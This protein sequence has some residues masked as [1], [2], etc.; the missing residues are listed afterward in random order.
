MSNSS[1]SARIKELGN[2]VGDGSMSLNRVIKSL[3]LQ[4]Y[5]QKHSQIY[6]HLYNS[7]K[8]DLL[9]QNKSSLATF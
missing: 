7:N 6:M 2:L 3:P 5:I 1:D 4:K 8:T 9:I